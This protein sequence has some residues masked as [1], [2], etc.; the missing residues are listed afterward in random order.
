MQ[1]KRLPPSF[2]A[3]EKYMARSKKINTATDSSPPPKTIEYTYRGG[4][5]PF[6]LLSDDQGNKHTPT[7]KEVVNIT[8]EH[9]HIVEPL[10]KDDV[11]SHMDIREWLSQQGVITRS[12]IDRLSDKKEIKCKIERL[13]T[14]KASNL[15]LYS[16]IECM[17][18]AKM[19]KTTICR[20]LS[21]KKATITKHLRSKAHAKKQQGI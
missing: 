12:K 17:L 16:Y 6:I 4:V 5:S 14:R 13:L 1:N 3:D 9:R 15:L 18:A 7:V 20:L 21:I 10:E 8:I 2:D 19:R 11:I